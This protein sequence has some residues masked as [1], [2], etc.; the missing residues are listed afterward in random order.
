[1]GKNIG[2]NIGKNLSNKYSQKLLYHTAKSSTDALKTAS[3]RV[4]QKPAEA[5]SD[6]LDNKIAN[7]ITKNYSKILQ[8]RLKGKQKFQKKDI[9]LQKKD[10]KLLMTTIKFKTAMLKSSLCDHSDAYIL[11]KRTIILVG[12]GADAA[13][14][15]EDRNNKQAI[16]KNSVYCL[17]N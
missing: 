6:F 16:F 1:M 2:K 9:Y 3:K 11:V 5:T 4:T 10:S 15:Q 8:K 7:K 13:A 17:Y 14:V 12:H